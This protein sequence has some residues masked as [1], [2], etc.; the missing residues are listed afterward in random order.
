M[1]FP[2]NPFNH[3]CQRNKIIGELLIKIFKICNIKDLK[4][5]LIKALRDLKFELVTTLLLGILVGYYLFV[6]PQIGMA[7]SADFGRIFPRIGLS[8]ISETPGDNF[9]NFFNTEYR[10]VESPRIPINVKQVIAFVSLGLNNLMNSGENYSI[11]YLSGL[12][13]LLYLAGFFL[14]LKNTFLITDLGSLQKVIICFLGLL[15]FSDILFVAYFNSFY[16]EALFIILGLYAAALAI[17]PRR[18]DNLLLLVMVLISVSKPQNLIFL[19]V[20]IYILISKFKWLNKFVIVFSGLILAFF[21]FFIIKGQSQTN[22]ANLYEAVFLGL[23]YDA[24]QSEQV[25]VL[26]TLDLQEEGYLKHVKR[27]YWRPKNEFF[28]RENKIHKEFYSR[29][30]QK[31]IIKAYLSHPLLFF[32][33]GLAGISELWNK[34]AQSLHLGN[35][36]KR[37]SYQGKLTTFQTIWGMWLN[38][39]LFPIYIGSFL[40]YLHLRK[41]VVGNFRRVII[42]LLLLIPLIFVANFVAGGIND[43]VKHNLSIYFMI[44][45]LFLLTATELLR[46]IKVF[47]ANVNK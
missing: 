9:F 25:K 42:S 22:K 4:L 1:I 20:P 8:R 3:L 27:I 40:L 35:Y 30:N 10:I 39:L 34:S 14:L 41:S 24:N 15:V 38:K 32:K 6:P 12:Y 44:S 43:F 37:D 33:T 17:A 21:M 11:Y 7:D 28:N 18:N 46:Q 47:Q 23:M 29:V 13:Y 45:I 5:R 36:K 26:N 2:V 16:Q 31:T 19:V